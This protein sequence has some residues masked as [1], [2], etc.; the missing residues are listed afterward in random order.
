MTPAD[1]IALSAAHGISLD[2]LPHGSAGT[3]RPEWTVAELGQAAYGVPR[4][5]FEAAC[6]AYAGDM[7]LQE[8]LWQALLHEATW[9]RRRERWP[10]TCR[11]IAGD[12]VNYLPPLARLVL[13]ED[14]HRRYFTV[15]PGLY[16]IYLGVT[17]PTWERELRERFVAV[18]LVYLGWLATAR[19]IMWPRL[20]D[21][22]DDE[23]VAPESRHG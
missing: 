12:T 9:L 5:A 16:A 22:P 10:P 1:L 23:T 7:G 17:E 11:G 19:R 3:A 13:V 21:E 6:Y 2:R 14:A 15:A 8:G 20:T 4:V 18:Q